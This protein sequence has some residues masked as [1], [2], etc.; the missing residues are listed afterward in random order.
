MQYELANDVEKLAKRLI[1]E[2]HQDL[3]SKKIVFVH[4]LKKDKNDQAVAQMRK[5]KAK[6]ADV[7]II[8]GLQAFLI[9]GE[10]A[11]DANG[12]D[13]FVVMTIS[14]HAWNALSP[15]QRPAA[16]DAQLCRLD[17]NAET[18]RPTIIDYDVNA[19]TRNVKKY[20]AWNEDLNHF[21][22]AAKQAPLFET[23]PEIAEAPATEPGTDRQ[24]KILKGGNGK[25]K[26]QEPVTDF[27][28][29]PASGVAE[30]KREVSRRRG[31]RQ[32]SAQK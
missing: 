21:F 14:K 9:S 13:A 28:R 32:P 15:E 5:G 31:G 3:A 11:T 12:P 1:R 23:Q 6:V 16:I 29:E 26:E 18:G 4:E 24:V 7:K 10:E 17:Y 30:M 19:S 25:D 27:R 22:A 2:D 8:G 20:G